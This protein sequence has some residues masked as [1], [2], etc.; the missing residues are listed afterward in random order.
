MGGLRDPHQPPVPAGAPLGG[1]HLSTSCRATAALGARSEGQPAGSSIG[2]AAAAFCRP[3][4][5]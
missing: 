2:G 1:L 5:S 3:G 4:S